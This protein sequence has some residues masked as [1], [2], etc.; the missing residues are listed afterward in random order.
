MYRLPLTTKAGNMATLE[1]PSAN[2]A[3]EPF[4]AVNFLNGRFIIHPTTVCP[5]PNH[6]FLPYALLG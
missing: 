6:R 4:T 3:V 2:L 1:A 5:A